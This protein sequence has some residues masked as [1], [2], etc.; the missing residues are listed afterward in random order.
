MAGCPSRGTSMLLRW[1]L[2]PLLFFAVSCSASRRVRLDI[3]D[4]APIL[5]A[6]PDA[7]EANLRASQVEAG[8]FQ[9]ALARLAWDVRPARQPLNHA[10]LLMGVPRRSGVYWYEGRSQRLIP[11]DE[12]DQGPRLRMSYADDELTR[13]YGQWCHRKGQSRDCL[14]LLDEGPLIASD[15][16][17]A[18]AMAIAMDSVWEET[19]EALEGMTDPQAVMATVTASVSMYLLLWAL[20]E[21][22][23]KGVAALITATA[24]AYLGVDMVWR[25]LDGWVSLVR[26]VDHA[27]TFEQLSEAGESYGEVLGVNAARVFVMLA[28]AAIGSTAGFAAKSSSLPN[29]ARAAL[30]IESQ[31]GLRFASIG[32]VGSVAMT[33][34]GFTVALAPTAVAMST[35]DSS[36]RWTH[37]HHLATNKNSVSTARGG[38]WTP[39]FEEFFKKAG[40]ELKDPENIVPVQGHH[41]P[42]PQEYH[43]LVFARLR[44]ATRACRTVESCR[45]ALTSALNEMAEE[46]IT[47]GTE[48]NRLVTRGK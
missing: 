17:Y 14:R 3:G 6:P 38:P 24:I 34:E 41:G 28:T 5:V 45:K 36:K 27:T 42:H 12:S 20:P 18:L 2:L 15:G 48:L 30:A 44:D 43:A 47:Q 8:A 39:R 7:T 37:Q 9:E 4:E 40:M 1:A 26:T 16:K 25:L 29:S 35:Q 19:A 10:R 33:A 21:P 46:V 11:Q 23:S 13:A 22:T 31:A 32:N